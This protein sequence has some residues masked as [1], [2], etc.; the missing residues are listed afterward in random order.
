MSNYK[1]LGIDKEMSYE[2]STWNESDL[3][4]LEDSEYFM[5]PSIT[6]RKEAKEFC[7][8]RVT[9]CEHDNWWYSKLLG[10]EF[11]CEIK[12]GDYGRGKFIRSFVGVKLTK[13][14]II[15]FR[16]FSPKDVSII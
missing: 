8:I 2:F 11:M 14:K 15:Y 7:H 13:N 6:D 16:D 12:Y 5:S 9:D 4:K 3:K 10:F 1:A